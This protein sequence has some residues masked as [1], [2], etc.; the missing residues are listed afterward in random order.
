M[1]D[2]WLYVEGRRQSRAYAASLRTPFERVRWPDFE[3]HVTLVLAYAPHWRTG[4]PKPKE[5]T[6]LQDFE[7]NV[8]EKLGDH[9]ALIATETY[10]TERTIHLVVGDGGLLDMFRA[11]ER[12]E[13]TGIGVTV[14]H[15]PQWL[16]LA[17]LSQVAA[18]AAA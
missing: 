5:L 4:L 12:K 6:R 3:F 18:R 16:T 17:H 11:W 7:D 1:K 10:D 9:G 13:Q 8:T 14:A 15:D 2:D